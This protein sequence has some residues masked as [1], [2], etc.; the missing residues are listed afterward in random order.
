MYLIKT[1]A[2]MFFLATSV[3]ALAAASGSS[4]KGKPLVEINGQIAEVKGQIATLEQRMDNLLS[5]VS[6]NESRIDG[7]GAAIVLLQ[8]ESTELE[9]QM[10]DLEAG[11]TSAEDLIAQLEAAN[12][13]LQAEL[14]EYGDLSGELALKI[15][16]NALKADTLTAHIDN[17]LG[18]LIPI[19]KAQQG[20]ASRFYIRARD[21]ADMIFTETEDALS[22]YK[23]RLTIVKS[24]FEWENSLSS[25]LYID[26]QAM[27]QAWREGHE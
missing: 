4:P 7:V 24:K 9:Q 22:H 20:S 15:E 21:T 19:A 27:A 11:L 13:S 1:I 2:L 10:R 8:E 5:R 16:A 25:M 18:G 23:N 14:D 3:S 26:A 17:G 12:D 6:L